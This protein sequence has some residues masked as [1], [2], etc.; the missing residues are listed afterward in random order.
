MCRILLL[1]LLLFYYQKMLIPVHILK[2]FECLVF[3]NSDFLCQ[4]HLKCVLN[5]RDFHSNTIDET[6][7]L[8]EHRWMQWSV[9]WTLNEKE[10]KR[11][12]VQLQYRNHWRKFNTFS[13]W[14]LFQ[15]RAEGRIHISAKEIKWIRKYLAIH[16]MCVLEK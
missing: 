1:L 6:Y 11:K 10:K 12:S 4:F 15:K 14:P 13:V 9:Y 5:I 16:R 2:T 7:Y 3:M 8:D